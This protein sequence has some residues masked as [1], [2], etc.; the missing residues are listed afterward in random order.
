[1]GLFGKVRRAAKLGMAI[2]N[3]VRQDRRPEAAP[4][5][6]LP[7]AERRDYSSEELRAFDGRDATTPILIAIEGRVFDVTRGRSFYG[8][9]GPYGLFA[10]HECALALAKLS[11]EEAHLDVPLGDLDEWEREKLDDWIETFEGKY[12]AIGRVTDGP[13]SAA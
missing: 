11:F 4:R 9:E 7:Q 3:E 8:P 13:F 1:M 5:V 6:P 2:V 10:G 12:D